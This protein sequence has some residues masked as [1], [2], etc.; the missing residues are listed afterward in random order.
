MI[1][2]Q[3][4]INFISCV[5]II[6]FRVHILNINASMHKNSMSDQI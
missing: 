2:K 3:C 1:L 6:I 5:Q 4:S